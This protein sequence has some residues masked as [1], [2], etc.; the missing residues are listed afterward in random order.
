MTRT[1]RGPHPALAAAGVA[2]VGLAAALVVAPGALAALL[3]VE[4]LVRS[5]PLAERGGR[6]LAVVLVGCGC[7]LWVVR[8]GASTD[9][10]ESTFDPFREE[11]AVGQAFDRRFA[12]AVDG[13]ADRRDREEVRETLRSLAVDVVTRTTSRSRASAL[14][15]VDRGEWT[16][17]PVAAAYVA[18]ELPPRERLRGW[19]RPRRA[20]ARRVERTVAA[21][22]ARLDD[23]GEP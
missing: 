17:D 12:R 16:D 20:T 3:P 6:A 11:S 19:V 7:L 1:R 23:G 15:V 18:G 10:G 21:L 22:E 8:S 4:A 2:A 13:A 5:T 14:E 9:D